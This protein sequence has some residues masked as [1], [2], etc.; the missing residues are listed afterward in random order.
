MSLVQA[1][2][3]IANMS[4]G[5]I[6][7]NQITLAVQ[8]STEGVQA[9]LFYAHCRDA[10][11]RSYDWNFSRARK[12]LVVHPDAPTFEWDHAYSL[13]D[14]FLRLRSDY[15]TS[16]S[17]DITD[18][19]EIEGS[20]LLTNDDEVE[21][22]YVRKVTDP[23]EFDP[24][25]KELLVLTLAIKLLF[26]LAGTSPLTMEMHARMNQELAILT[27]RAKQI[28]FAE[29]PDSGRSDWNWARYTGTV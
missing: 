20:M 16:D 19:W 6:G 27:G 9:N 10:L 12:S 25:F 21:L 7:A 14:D 1:E 26:P 29:G 18:R 11:L 28:A 22:K 3:D 24:L 8:T 15:T 2:V 4:L 13:P 23:D 17:Q 5:R